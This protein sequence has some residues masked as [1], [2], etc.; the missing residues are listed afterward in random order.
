MFTPQRLFGEVGSS[1]EILT[2][3]PFLE[4]ARL[5]REQEHDGSARLALG[6]YVVARLVDKLLL[7]EEEG[8]AGEGFRWQLEAV[9]HHVNDLPSDAPETAHLA[10]VVAAVP[11]QGPPSSA[12]WKSLTAYA[13]FLEHEA[14]LDE[15][16]EVLTLAC[17]TQGEDTSVCDFASYALAAGRLNR[18]L[19]RW[20]AATACYA[21]AEE[22]A[23]K[24]GDQVR[25]LRGRLGLGA[26]NR[27]LGNLPRARSIA[28]SV[29]RD[30][31]ELQLPEVQA[32]AYADLGAVFALQGLRVQELEANYSAFRL[33][34]D[35]V[36]RMRTLGDLGIGLYRLGAR[37][38]AR[39]AFEIVI[40]SNTSL[41]VRLNALLELMDLESF[42]GN[43]VA[44]ERYRNMI[45]ESRA[46]LSPSMAT[47]FQYKVGVGLMRFGRVP[48][49]RAALVEGLALA[50][51]HRLN[52][53]YFKIEQ[54]L[55]SLTK[56]SVPQSVTEQPVEFSAAPEILKMEQ[57]LREYASTAT[58]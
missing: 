25:A 21:A 50:E 35:P 12:L 24:I 57:G 3:E 1:P 52:A 22:A 29:V 39:L 43:R 6:A 10:G 48:R 45:E 42:S 23:L 16:L 9:R 20:D 5:Q 47:D 7:R 11:E 4:R 58:H 28:E 55:A 19:A 49:G 18:Q 30:A 32:L 44:F 13:Y 40:G 56:E 17:R 37:D 33:T 38:A 46:S 2:H 53:W 51:R 14:R 27:G 34:P 36:Q 31:S 15:A 54:A 26:V 8:D 41:V